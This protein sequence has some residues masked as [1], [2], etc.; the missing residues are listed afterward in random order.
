MPIYA[1][2]QPLQEKLR[3]AAK[4]LCAMT[5]L[6]A[7]AV[8]C[9]WAFDLPVLR[10]PIPA[11]VAMNPMSAA[12]FLLCCIAINGRASPNLIYARIALLSGF[13]VLSLSLLKLADLFFGTLL[14]VDQWLFRPLLERDLLAGVPNRMAPNAA[15]GFLFLSLAVIAAPAGRAERKMPAQWALVPVF[16]IAMMGL[17]GYL[18]RVPRFYGVL[19]Y[20]PIAIHTATCLLFA[21]LALLF[22]APDRG[23]MRLFTTVYAGSRVAR[24]LITGVVAVPVLV[25][26][27]HLI[28]EWNLQFPVEFGV[29]MLVL[30]IMGTLLLFVWY[31]THRLNKEDA[32]K[33]TALR[34]LST[35]NNELESRVKQETERALHTQTR[36]QQVLDNML[37]GVQII[38]RNWIYLYVNAAV[39]SQAQMA[40]SALL[41]KCVLKIYPGVEQT[42]L[43]R[44][45]SKSMHDHVAQ[46]LETPFQHADGRLGWYEMSIQPIPEGIFILTVDITERKRA[47]EILK[48][49]NEELELRVRERTRQ[50]ED[51]NEELKS[52]SYSVSHD[53]RS[54]L[55]TIKGYADMLRHLNRG[56]LSEESE[57]LIAIINS[58][59]DKMDQLINI[60]LKLAHL[61]A[62]TLQP[63]NILT[64]DLVREVISDL[65]KIYP[66]T[67]KIHLGELPPINGDAVLLRQVFLNLI[68]NA[69]KYSATRE[70]PQIAVSG[71]I[72]DQEN[73]FTISDNGVGFDMKFADKLFGVFQRLH[74]A[75]DFP[76]TGVGLA[77]VQRIVHKHG[78]RVWAEST[79]GQGAAFRFSLPRQ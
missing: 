26:F 69:L 36:L 30:S 56:K 53:L 43:F 63:E 28:S 19:N 23:A 27:L 72:S 21:A 61:G 4:Y 52:F 7:L 57:R 22:S 18:Y 60:T 29:A 76:G 47:E 33:Q 12:L 70:N 8:L 24:R 49:T 75:E 44:V 74:R 51:L 13:A 25:G 66:H 40:M 68:D 55:R 31:V 62:Q 42:D 59:V 32:E 65:V 2:D 5:T 9:G 78:G 1:N 67:D 11:F 73:V 35:L 38:D 15:M 10:R 58:G 46:Q 39:A 14:G 20:T 6:I 54:P 17:I 34:Q 3:T 16:A 71:A 50:L 37:E 45:L 77:T 64:T 41:G 48:T 79:P